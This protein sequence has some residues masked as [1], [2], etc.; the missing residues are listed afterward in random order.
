MQRERE[1][2]KKETKNKCHATFYGEKVSLH[3]SQDIDMSRLVIVSIVV[4]E[5]HAATAFTDQLSSLGDDAG[6]T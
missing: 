4:S 5:E 3:V 6:H 2:K 1:R